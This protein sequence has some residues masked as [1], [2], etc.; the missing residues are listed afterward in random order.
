MSKDTHQL[1]NE[2]LKGQAELAGKV[3]RLAAIVIAN[4]GSEEPEP[5]GPIAPLP[6]SPPKPRGSGLGPY[7]SLKEAATA[8]ELLNMKGG[9]D[10]LGVLAAPGAGEFTL[11]PDIDVTTK[12]FLPGFVWHH[13]QGRFANGFEMFTPSPG[14]IINSEFKTLDEA[15]T[16]ADAQGPNR[17]VIEVS[18]TLFVVWPKAIGSGRPPGPTVY[19]TPMP[20]EV[21]D[22]KHPGADAPGTD[23]EGR[24]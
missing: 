22:V 2:V 18:P 10:L 21:P 23:H 1:L 3:D 5:S 24:G 20:P 19:T 14:G 8:A 13:D 4:S 12:G 16:A 9:Q 11:A 6:T 17:D 7:A 15:K